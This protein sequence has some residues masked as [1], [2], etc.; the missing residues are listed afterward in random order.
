MV[1]QSFYHVSP[2]SV[3]PDGKSIVVVVE[4]LN[5]ESYIAIYPIDKT[6]PPLRF[7]RPHVPKEDDHKNPILNFPNF[8][9]ASS[10]SPQAREGTIVTV[11]FIGSIQRL[12]TWK[13]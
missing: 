3:S 9:R 6:G 11:T 8:I 10:L 4:D 5:G 12:G 7:L 1:T 13:C 2:T